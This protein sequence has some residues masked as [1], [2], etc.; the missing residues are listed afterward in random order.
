LKPK[1]TDQKRRN[2][3]TKKGEEIGESSQKKEEAG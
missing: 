1:L 2:Q 3:K